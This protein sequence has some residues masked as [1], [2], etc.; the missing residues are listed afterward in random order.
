[1][2]SKLKIILLVALLLTMTMGV[3]SR[4]HEQDKR[5]THKDDEEEYEDE[6][7]DCVT[8]DNEETDDE[9]TEDDSEDIDDDE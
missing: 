3:P 8:D 7:D 2:F 6:I 9:V 5:G 4:D 1:M